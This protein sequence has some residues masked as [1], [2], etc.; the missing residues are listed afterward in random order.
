MTDEVIQI[1]ERY[2]IKATVTLHADG[3]NITT[4]A[5]AREADTKKGMDESQITGAA[6]SYAR[7]YALSGLFAIDDNKDADALKNVG[8]RE[9]SVE[10]TNSLLDL[11]EMKGVMLETVCK[12]YNIESL[13][14]LPESKYAEVKSRL[15]AKP[16]KEAR[17]K[18]DKK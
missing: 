12:A 18:E 1:G 9:I 10:Q 4:Q 7:K 13:D 11:I 16:D 14:R 8:E 2:Y 17:Q 3:E 5:L 6:S 15:E